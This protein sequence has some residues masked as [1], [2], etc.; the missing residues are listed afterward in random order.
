MAL[1]GDLIGAFPKS[2]RKLL[3]V[4]AGTPGGGSQ[5]GDRTTKLR[6]LTGSRLILFAELLEHAAVEV[7]N[8]GASVVETP[9]GLGEGG[10]LGPADYPLIPAVLSDALQEEGLGVGVGIP[11]EGRHRLTQLDLFRE[12]HAGMLTAADE[13]TSFH[14]TQERH[15]RMKAL[16]CGAGGLSDGRSERI[17]IC[18][19]LTLI[20]H[21][22]SGRPEK[23]REERREHENNDAVHI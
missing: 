5:T 4:L 19:F 12:E 22:S 15:P 23:S 9:S 17:Q 14:S 3:V 16:L 7:T 6:A 11:E 13:K 8:S 1:L 10:V 2:W 21:R 18:S 20:L